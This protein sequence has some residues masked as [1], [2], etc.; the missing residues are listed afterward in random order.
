MYRDTPV[1]YLGNLWSFFFV[2]FI[3]SIFFCFQL[4]CYLTVPGY[5][6]EVGEAF[7]S[8]VPKFIVHLSYVIASGYVLADTIHKG[9]KVYEVNRTINEKTREV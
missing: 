9:H 6:N 1:R 4:N 3:Q 7:R 2:I 8:I 5:T